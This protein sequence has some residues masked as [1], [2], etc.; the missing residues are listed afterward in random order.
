MRIRNGRLAPP[1]FDQHGFALVDH[2]TEVADLFDKERLAVAYYPEVEAL[3]KRV[4]GAYRVHVFDYTMRSGDEAERG[5]RQIREP[6]RLAHNDY[7][8]RSAPQRVRDLLPDEA[9][10]LLRGRFAVI[11]VWRSVAPR[12]ERNPLALCAWRSVAPGDLI[13]SERRYSN[14]IG[15]IYRLRYNPAHEWFY[16]PDMRRDEAIVFKVH[17]SATDGRARFTPHTSFDDPTT[18]S[19]APP[20][21]SI[22]VRTLAFF[23]QS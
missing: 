13:A 7:T 3:V 21:Q 19:G 9:D 2:A 4:S 10:E 11:Q 20:R 23:G 15:E 14:R 18:P 8:E 17:D 6:I 16:F 12:V 22:E 1:A 5:E